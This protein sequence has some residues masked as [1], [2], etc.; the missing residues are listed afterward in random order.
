M[1]KYIFQ[2]ERLGFRNWTVDDLHPFSQMNMDKDVMEFFPNKLTF[3]QTKIFLNR[4]KKEFIQNGFTFY[5]VEIVENGEFIGFIGIE[6]ANFDADFTPCIEI[7]WRLKKSAWNRGYATE[8]AIKCLYYAFSNL[9]I[10]TIYSFTAAIN[11]KSEN[12]MKKIGMKKVGEFLH[13]KITKDHKLNPHVLYRIN[14]EIV[15]Q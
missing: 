9:N 10:E 4:L 3:N 15:I 11:K 7:G 1:S 13:T 6:E 12:V 14:K 2:S 8:G 5:A